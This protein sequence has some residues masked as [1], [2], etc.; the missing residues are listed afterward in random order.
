M[1]DLMIGQRKT[2]MVAIGTIIFSLVSIILLQALGGD[3]KIVPRVVRFVFTC[4]FAFFLW[5]GAGWAR[6]LV[7]ILSILAV[8]MSII[9]FFGL[10]AAGVPMFSILG[11]WMAV[12]TMFYAWVSYML[13]I[14]KDVGSHFNPTSGF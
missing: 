3:E 6:W 5:K 2:A 9:G 4:V 13:L 7:G 11:I 8:I 1:M 14:D 12:M 10:S